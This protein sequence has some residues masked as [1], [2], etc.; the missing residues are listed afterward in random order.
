MFQYNSSLYDIETR[1]HH[2]MHDFPTW[3][4]GARNVLR[5]RLPELVCQFPA[6]LIRK[7]QAYSITAFLKSYKA[8]Y[9]GII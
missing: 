6:D 9:S 8:S 5:L 2:R 4:F 7:T 3:T 1:N